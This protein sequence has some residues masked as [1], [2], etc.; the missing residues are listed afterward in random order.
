MP[1]TSRTRSKQRSG[2]SRTRS[3]SRSKSES[4]STRS[5]SRSRGRPRSATRKSA[6]SPTVQ[7][8]TKASPA[9]QKASTPKP[10]IT[11]TRQSARLVEK[12]SLDQTDDVKK[13]VV[14]QKPESPASSSPASI[15]P[16]YLYG[17]PIGA[18]L[19]TILMPA[20]LIVISQLCDKKSCMIGLPALPASVA[21]IFNYQSFLLLLGWVAFQAV[22]ASLPVG[23]KVK[24]SQ[25]QGKAARIYHCN[26]L[27]AFVANAAVVGGLVYEG[28]SVKFVVDNFTQL[29]GSAILFSFLFSA[30]LYVCSHFSQATKHNPHRRSGCP[31]YDFFAG[32]ELNPVWGTLDVKFY[33]VKLSA[34]TWAALNASFFFEAYTSDKLSQNLALVV[35]LQTCYLIDMLYFEEGWLKSM[36]ASSEGVGFMTTFGSVGFV[37]FFYVIQTRYLFVNQQSSSLLACIVFILTFAFGYLVFRGSNSQK[38]KFRTDPHNPMFAGLETIPTQSGKRLLAAGW[39]GLVRHPNYLGD[40]IISLAWTLPCGFAPALP[41]VY[42]AFLVLMLVDRASTDNALCSAK[43]GPAWVRYCQRVPYMIIPR[44]Y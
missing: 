20:A 38:E 37:P 22:L 19:T 34:L 6:K 23:K 39:W 2:A 36:V 27:F 44:I 11:P 15:K 43:Y 3:K 35:A 16:D 10:R 30:V 13:D 28:Y 25:G 29:A 18:F 1:S 40:I 9:R 31:S 21:A 7:S 8:E 5:R 41:W 4:R 24:V 26:G 33:L 14:D 42:M 17:G 12:A 32:V